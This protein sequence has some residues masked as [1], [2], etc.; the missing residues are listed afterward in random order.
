MSNNSGQAQFGKDQWTERTVLEVLLL[1]T[2]L[3]VIG[4]FAINTTLWQ[5]AQ[6]FWFLGLTS[7][8]FVIAAFLINRTPLNFNVPISGKPLVPI[9]KKILYPLFAIAGAVTFF[10]MTKTSYRIA[11]PRFQVIEPGLEGN[12]ILATFAAIFEDNF[13]FVGLAG[14]TFTLVY[15]KTKKPWLAFM[16][17]LMVVPTIFMLYHFSVYGIDSVESWAVFIFGLEM[18]V[19]MIVLRDV[20]YVHARHVFN[21]LGILVF[22]AMDTTTFT[23]M[24]LTSWVFWL[25]VIIAILAVVLTLRKRR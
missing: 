24:L 19:A 15:W 11:V 9:S 2:G 22:E 18:T 14:L 5:T 3:A 23:I 20:T 21:N 6:I 12:S 10:V 4:F 13:F 8:I 1:I 17:V 16:A 7:T 25:V